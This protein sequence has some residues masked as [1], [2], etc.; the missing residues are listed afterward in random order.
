MYA[1]RSYYADDVRDDVL[2]AASIHVV[3]GALDAEYEV[4]CGDRR[5]IGPDDSVFQGDGVGRPVL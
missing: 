3:T 2:V 4:A 5:A 1:I